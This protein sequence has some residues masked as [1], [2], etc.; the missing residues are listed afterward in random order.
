MGTLPIY[1]QNYFQSDIIE[2]S[3]IAP[4]C[5]DTALDR[6]CSAC[7]SRSLQEIKRFIAEHSALA[8]HHLLQR[9]RIVERALLFATEIL[10]ADHSLT[11]EQLNEKSALHLFMSVQMTAQWLLDDTLDVDSSIEGEVASQIIEYYLDLMEPS[12]EPRID[13]PLLQ[14]ACSRNGIPAS[15]VE[16]LTLLVRWQH[17]LAISAGISLDLPSMYCRLNRKFMRS[18]LRAH[19]RFD[20]L[21]SYF[22]HRST[23]CG[24]G[25]EILCGARWFCRLWGV[26]HSGLELHQDHYDA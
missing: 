1:L 7:E 26:D 12:G 6:T 22:R 15:F 20:S 8:D 16:A 18:Y 2:R 24:L 17:A 10:G 21:E 25:V 9:R 3:F 13:A 4:D 19:S 14:A 11:S 5:L 23:N